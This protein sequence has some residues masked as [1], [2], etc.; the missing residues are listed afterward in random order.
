M[1]IALFLPCSGLLNA[2]GLK[3]NS[4]GQFKVLQFTDL[5]FVSDKPQEAAKTFSRMDYIV[6]AESPD[7]IAVTGDVIYGMQPSAD[8]LKAVLD[9]LDSYGIPF[10]I[11]FGNHDAEQDLS[12]PEMSAMIASSKYSL[13]KLND[14]GELADI[15][16]GVASSDGTSARVL[17]IF[18]LDSHD[19]SKYK[20][21]GGYAWFTSDQ[22]QWL[23]S[24]CEASAGLCGRE[25]PS[26]SF[27][28]IPLPEF[29]NA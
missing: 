6:G 19:Y 7:Y 11:V 23:R 28:H 22:I 18:M 10:C 3:F 24:E 1:L 29:Y 13:N 9:K 16:L 25:V 2:Q 15:K 8:M 20:E 21:V 17:D 4:D 5:H 12:R 27:F 14:D 26:V